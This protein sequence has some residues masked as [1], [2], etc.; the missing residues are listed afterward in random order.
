ML[1]SGA[2]AQEHNALA[3]RVRGSRSDAAHDAAHDVSACTAITIRP[4]MAGSSCLDPALHGPAPAHDV[5][6]KRLAY[7]LMNWGVAVAI[8]RGPG[9]QEL[10]RKRVPLLGHKL[11]QKPSARLHTV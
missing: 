3:A 5:K 11:L 9:L 7:S 1:V 10:S 2:A 6:T 4:E 8:Q